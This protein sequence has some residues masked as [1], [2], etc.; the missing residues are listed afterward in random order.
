MKIQGKIIIT[1]FLASWLT[2][3]FSVLS[4]NPN[5]YNLKE[6]KQT[7]VPSTSKITQKIENINE[8]NFLKLAFYYNEGKKYDLPKILINNEELEPLH[9][10]SKKS[11]EQIYYNLSK[12]V[13]KTDNSI[14]I[15]AGSELPKKIN[16]IFRNYRKS[17]YNHNLLIF[18]KFNLTNQPKP[19]AIETF[20]MFLFTFLLFALLFSVAERNYCKKVIHSVFLITAVPALVAANN[21][22]P[23]SIYSVYIAKYT[24]WLILCLSYLSMILI[25]LYLHQ[26]QDMFLIEDAN[27]QN[28]KKW[29]KVAIFAVLGLFLLGLKAL[30]ILTS[31]VPMGHDTFQYLQLNYNLFFNEPILHNELPQWLP[32]MTHGTNSAI[33]FI[34]SQNMLS[35]FLMPMIKFF[36]G[37][38]YYP[39]FQAG[40]LFDELALLLGCILFAKQYFK[41]NVT[42][43]FISSSLVLTTIS[44]TQIWFDFH[45]VYLLPLWFYCVERAFKE[46]SEKYIL[47]SGLLFAGMLIGN[48]PYF[49]PIFGFTICLF[50][51][52]HSIVCPQDTVTAFRNFIAHLNWKH[53]A[54]MLISICFIVAVL[55]FCRDGVTT[56]ANHNEGRGQ[57]LSVDNVKLFMSYGG[58]INLSKYFELIG[59]GTN[60][61]NN[62]IYGGILIVPFTLMAVLTVRRRQSYVFGLTAFMMVLFSAGILVPLV[63][64][65][66]FPFAKYY[67]HIGLVAPIAKFFLVFYA[68]FGF[69]AFW[70]NLSESKPLSCSK[71]AKSINI[72]LVMLFVAVFYIFIINFARKLSDCILNLLPS[73]GFPSANQLYVTTDQINSLANLVTSICGALMLVLLLILAFPKYKKIILP[74]LLLIHLFDVASFKFQNEYCKMAH[75]DKNVID[76][77]KPYDYSFQKKRAQN[78][79]NDRF[80]A[81]LPE[82][83]WS[84]DTPNPLLPFSCVGKWGALYWNTES[85]LYVDTVASIFRTDHWQKSIDN[86]FSVWNSEKNMVDK[87]LGF[88]IPDSKVFQNCAGVNKN[89]LQVFSKI[90]LLPGE[91]DIKNIMKNE[92]YEADILLCNSSDIN[93]D[94]N[95]SDFIIEPDADIVLD[96]NDRTSD[97]DI[98]V[99][100]FSFN[101]LNL[102]I[103]NHSQDNRV[104]YYA[105]AWNPDW[106]A[107]IDGKKTEVIKTNLGYKSVIVPT[108]QS[109]VLFTF[110]NAR[111][112]FL[113]KSLIVI[114]ICTFLVVNYLMFVD[115]RKQDFE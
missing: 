35:S 38:N 91:E 50:A 10:I 37:L 66:C 74:V 48:L 99:T 67:R 84:N 15:D 40:L 88:P 82:C 77:F 24:L 106:K 17:F 43:F 97:V 55:I 7:V 76:L 57:N 11:S 25:G 3:T 65:Y 42:V 113:F 41:S 93:S 34:I 60:N 75:T 115:L 19:A 94:S 30:I 68:G 79:S 28:N 95:K 45:L 107:F 29:G 86:F 64:Y 61:I 58:Y 36:S 110:G 20:T 44:S 54:A 80:D 9:V 89:K 105:D 1:L 72:R 108:G 98:D 62:I 87:H 112:N 31:R 21:L 6:T 111:S 32:F 63:F 70:N 23:F 100:G 22:L 12:S 69:D 103:N 81:I 56:I 33:W 8:Q 73:A 51:L 92:N 14:T 83:F 5:E 90:H 27:C 49:A 39:I 101:K 104:I 52:I 46:H 78:Y 59:R 71:A 47:F 2:F 4:F 109:Q 102:K 16:F 26:K 18:Y 53:F 114:G 96:A 85:F 13:T